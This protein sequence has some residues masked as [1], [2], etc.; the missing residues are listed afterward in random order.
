MENCL[1]GP[2]PN[3]MSPGDL[4]RVIDDGIACGMRELRLE[5]VTKKSRRSKA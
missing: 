3:E 4:Y 2:C 1:C 5:K